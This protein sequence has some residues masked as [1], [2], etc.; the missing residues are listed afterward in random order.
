M[1][2]AMPRS[3]TLLCLALSLLSLS[4]TCLMI[5]HTV[6]DRLQTHKKR[7]LFKEAAAFL[8][9]VVWSMLLCLAVKDLTFDRVTTLAIRWAMLIY[10]LVCIML[11]LTHVGINL[12]S[13]VIA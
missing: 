13:G 8:F 2:N 7:Y 5:A 4:A 3:M 6:H 12:F 10:P 9:F 1:L 11:A